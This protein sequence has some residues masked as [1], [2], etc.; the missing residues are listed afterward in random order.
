[1]TDIERYYRGLRR[2]QDKHLERV[3]GRGWKPC[4]HDQCP[5]CIG[6][7]VKI[8]GGE[9]HHEYECDCPVCN[10]VESE[11]FDFFDVPASDTAPPVPI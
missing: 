5:F 2:R 11:S 6:T 8:N 9:C 7:H 10:P 4:L 1:M 3:H